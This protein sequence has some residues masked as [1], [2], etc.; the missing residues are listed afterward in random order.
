MDGGRNYYGGGGGRG[1]GGRSYRGG[2]GRGRGGGGRHRHHHQPY[3]NNRRGRGGGGRGNRF[4]GNQQP[5]VDPQMQ[6]LKQVYS[7]VSRIGELK[8]VDQGRAT[9]E[10]RAVEATTAGNINEIVGLLCEP[11]KQDFLLKYQLPVEGI[12]SKPEE[13]V[14]RL[15]HLVI[16]CVGGLPLQTPCYAALTLAIHEEVKGGTW[17]GFADRCLQYTMYQIAKDLD[18]MF[19]EG[20]DLSQGTCRLKLMV[21]YLAILGRMDVVK[22]Y[23]SEKADDINSLT[24]VSLLCLLVQAATNAAQQHGNM[25]AAVVLATVVLSSIPYIVEYTPPEVIEEKLIQPVEALLADYKSTFTPG[26]GSTAVL[27]KDEQLE[28]ADDDEEEDDDDDDDDDEASGQVC[29]S[30]QDLIRA[31][32]QL[33]KQS[34]NP[35][36]VL[37]K[38]APWKGLLTRPQPTLEGEA[39]EPQPLLYTD[40]AK[41]LSFSSPCKVL[42]LLIQNETGIVLQCFDLEGVVFGRLPIFGSP[43]DPDDDD[44]DEEDMDDESAKNEK[45]QAFVKGFSLLDRYFVADALRD[46]FI[47]Q[48]GAVSPTGLLRGSAKHVA[49]ELL[50]VCYIFSGETPEA[51]LEYAILETVFGLIAQSSERGSLRHIFLSRVL[52]ELTRLQPSKLSP[53]LVVGMTNIFND[54]LPALAPS[55]RENLSRWFS[56]HLVNTDYQWPPAL[57]KVWEPFAVASKQSSRGD[58]VIRSLNLM[59][60]NL[61]NP[62]SLLKDCLAGVESLDQFLLGSSPV[63]PFVSDEGTPLTML[64]NEVQKRLWENTEDPSLLQQ[65][66]TGDEVSAS[67]QVDYNSGDVNQIWWRTGV[68]IRVLLDP[69]RQEHNR[70]KLS[71][72][73]AKNPQEDLMEDDIALSK[74]VFST[75]TDAI[76]R[77]RQVLAGA[78]AK[79]AATVAKHVGGTISEADLIQLGEAYLAQQVESIASFSRSTLEGALDCLVRNKCVSALGVIRWSL[80]DL[81][82]GNSSSVVSRWWTFA[83]Q[84]VRASLVRT[85]ESDKMN[86]EGG[87][88]M[89][90]DTSGTDGANDSSRAEALAKAGIEQVSPML[91]Y[92]VTRVCTVL[93]SIENSDNKRLLPSQIELVEGMK[94]LL[95]S[96]DITLKSLYGPKSGPETAVSRSQ[97]KAMIDESSGGCNGKNLASICAS[98]GGDNVAVSLLQSSLE[99]M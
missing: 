70:V 71:L 43:S 60:E 2:R 12:A 50:S 11:E 15:V 80:G 3:N 35:R 55:A 24:V 75:F 29:D 4:R 25:T 91:Q 64:Q 63:T 18:T 66:L 52:L 88:G 31:T 96:V 74:D 16:G 6:M 94:C 89:V 48:E 33:R 45:L 32:Q 28:D 41:Y 51:G 62:E 46:C 76:A 56:F 99:R 73:R 57:W 9:A 37:P 83:S 30:L 93:V 87:L 79:D 59:A 36:F 5:Y 47:S 1:G 92:A 17:A 86:R 58:F 98:G 85:L 20:L 97:L 7:I 67:I 84:S 13:A 27:L 8:N 14:G 42:S 34:E 77:Y 72:E 22:G 23:D 38:D 90:I 69:V 78:I 95:A 49:E 44:D 54:Y 19:I 65:Y 53:A 68:A 61:T 82:E 21:R 26:V 10:L 39:G 40:G 81:G